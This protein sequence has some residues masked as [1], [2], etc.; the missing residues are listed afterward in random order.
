MSFSGVGSNSDGD[1]PTFFELIAA[2]RLVT[3]LQ[4]AIS[5]G[6]S[7]YGQ[8]SELCRR[9]LDHEDEL[10]FL[11]RTML[12]RLS[13]RTHGASFAESVYG[14]R[15]V[16]VGSPGIRLSPSQKRLSLMLL[17]LQPFLKGTL[18]KFY[19]KIHSNSTR[20]T[21]EPFLDS[22]RRLI[23]REK[24]VA[25]AAGLVLERSFPLV[26]TSLEALDMGYKLTYLLGMT[27][28]FS[29]GLHAI[30]IR[31][32]RVSP[33]DRAR[34]LQEKT[35]HRQ[36]TLDALSRYNS[37]G[38]IATLAAYLRRKYLQTRFFVN[39][40]ATSALVLLV[41][42]FKVVEWWY[43][44]AEERM[45]GSMGPFPVP[46]PPPAVPPR[47][48]MYSLPKNDSICAICREKRVNPTMVPQS[49]YVFCYTCVFRHVEKHN[50]CPVTGLCHIE[51]SDLRRLF[52]SSSIDR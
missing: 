15:R 10:F 5:Y 51:T 19:N 21:R 34:I 31:V 42:G 22:L 47:G 8:R 40:H 2:D 24:D 17:T 25:S 23:I 52:S 38:W 13:L 26:Y 12:E 36:A 44:S 3:T 14:L 29:P 7:V 50:T 32:S 46:P 37:Q 33:H 20:S 27:Q 45:Q 43:T 6:L 16:P 18:M 4:D 9:L 11:L 49:G 48:G 28:Y 41:F 39:D 30:G 1:L 35:R